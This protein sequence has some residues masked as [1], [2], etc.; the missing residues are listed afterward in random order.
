MRSRPSRGSLR[1][2]F[3]HSAGFNNV[4]AAARLPLL[5]LLVEFA[6]VPSLLAQAGTLVGAF[7]LRYLYHSRVVYADVSAAAQPVSVRV[8][9]TGRRRAGVRPG[10]FEHPSGGGRS[11][12]L[13][14]GTAS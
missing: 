13:L 8:P 11:A 14:D 10:A 7:L 12:L 9:A 3:L 2:R 4:D 1:R 6:G 5:W